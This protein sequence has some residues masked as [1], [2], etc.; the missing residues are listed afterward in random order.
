MTTKQ[1][2]RVEAA[3]DS[4]KRGTAL[5]L[6]ARRL[7]T[8]YQN[9]RYAFVKL[10]GGSDRFEQLRRRGAGTI[11]ERTRAVRGLRMRRV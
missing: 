8:R 7:H 11:G 1:M 4:W 10:A 2:S 3:Y 5:G 9:L 6:L